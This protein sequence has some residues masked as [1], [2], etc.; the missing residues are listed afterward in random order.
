MTLDQL[1]G[2]TNMG[3]AAA[4]S[5]LGIK[6]ARDAGAAQQTA[7]T[8]MANKYQ[9]DIQF[10]PYTV[11]GA[12]GSSTFAPGGGS[13]TLSPQLQAMMQQLLT[14][15]GG[16][17]SGAAQPI[18]QRAMDVTAQLEAAS[19]PSRQREYLSM[20]QRLFN[21]GRGGLQTA[22]YGGAPEQFAFAK[23]LE[24]QRAQNALMG[25][26]Q[27]MNEQT[28]QL[29][30][31]QGLFNNAFV[32][33]QQ[34]NM[35]TQVNTPFAE[36]INRAQQQGAVT[37]GELAGQGTQARIAGETQANNLRQVQLQGLLDALNA[38][39]GGGTSFLGSLLGKLFGGG[40]SSTP[41]G[42]VTPTAA[43]QNAALNL[44]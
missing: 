23:A 9:S 41:A 13:S 42:F 12:T 28:Q 36:L 40:T 18:D 24:E 6:E 7:L 25:R 32:P 11:T 30:I 29:N 5:N 31:G 4:L 33:Q 19:A 44:P 43:Q 27:A 20:E 38:P 2:I 35:Q 37:G 17:F 39:A 16:M 34:M 26:T 14:S 21:Q 22:Q 3:G 15:S 1:L 8:D 10:K